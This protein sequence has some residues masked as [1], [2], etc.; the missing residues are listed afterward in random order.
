ML[1]LDSKIANFSGNCEAFSLGCVV[2]DGKR[3]A[4]SLQVCNTCAKVFYIACKRVYARACEVE[5]ECGCIDNEERD[6]SDGCSVHVHF[7]NV[8]RYVELTRLRLGV[9]N[10][11]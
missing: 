10:P 3:A 5:N 7:L 1:F 6:Q 8:F 11:C 2:G 9:F 4:D